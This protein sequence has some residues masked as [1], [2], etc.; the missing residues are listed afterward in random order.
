[1]CAKHDFEQ[2]AMTIVQ[3]STTEA[4]GGRAGDISCEPTAATST[5]TFLRHQYL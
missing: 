5:S 1:M 3:T 2:L 4:E